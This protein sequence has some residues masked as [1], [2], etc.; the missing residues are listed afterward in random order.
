MEQN[1]S[2]LKHECVSGLLSTIVSSEISLTKMLLNSFY[3][4]YILDMALT[5]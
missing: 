1:L 4:W 3:I 5:F 2:S